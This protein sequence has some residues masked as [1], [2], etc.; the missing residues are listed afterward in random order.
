MISIIMLFNLQYIVQPFIEYKAFGMQNDD[1]ILISEMTLIISPSLPRK[2][3]LFKW[4]QIPSVL[5]VQMLQCSRA[6]WRS[7]SRLSFE[8][9]S[10]YYGKWALKHLSVLTVEATH[11]CDVIILRMTCVIAADDEG[12]MAHRGPRLIKMMGEG[13]CWLCPM[14]TSEMGPGQ[15]HVFLK[16][17]I[18]GLREILLPESN[19]CS[20]M[21]AL[22][23]LLALLG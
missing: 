17:L 16:L 15:S 5:C 8:M 7:I 13:L 12:H 19:D 20:V 1:T 3:G 18:T 9:M 11:T 21:K 10:S 14:Y 2:I 23:R 6:L 4:T 22:K